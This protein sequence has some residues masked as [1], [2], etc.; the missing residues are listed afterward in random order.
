M[1]KLT[2]RLRRVGRW[3]KPVYAVVVMSAKKPMRGSF[4]EKLGFYSPLS[5]S[6]IFFINLDRLSF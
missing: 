1:H 6:K 3:R 2:I 4:L 5:S